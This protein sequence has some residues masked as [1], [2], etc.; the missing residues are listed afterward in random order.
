[1]SERRRSV[2]GIDITGM[3]IGAA[4][5]A[6]PIFEWVRP[7]ILLI[8]ERYQRELS[9]ASLR[10]I[11]KILAG[12]DWRRFK[13]PVVVMTDAGLDLIDGQHTA[14]AAAS[15]PDIDTIPVM[16]VE[17]SELAQRAAAFIGHN[18]DRI[19]VNAAQIHHAAVTAGDEDA[20]TVQ[21]VCGRAG[22]TILRGPPGRA[23]RAGET[24][25]ISSVQTLIG[26]RGAMRARQ[27][28]EALVKAGRAPISGNDI[29]AGE[30]LLTDPDYASEMDADVLVGAISAAGVSA[31]HDA[32]LFAAAHKIP[33][34]KALGIVWFKKK[35]RSRKAE[36]A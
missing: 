32:K 24:V 9:G 2:A 28:L 20:L 26:R 6:K 11:A 10:L 18:R 7:E 17:A 16:I 23:F 13:P 27:I 4:D 33:Y 21:Q 1:M 35:G 5:M 29:K 15:H 25:A 34:W 30:M 22:V 36:P 19:A 14:I 12:W 3:Q 31:E 8:D